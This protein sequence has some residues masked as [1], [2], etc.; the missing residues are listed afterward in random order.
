MAERKP[1]VLVGGRLEELPA[2]DT[3]QAQ[4]GSSLP[5]FRNKIINGD[6]RIDQR[7]SGAAV[8]Y[9]GSVSAGAEMYALDRWLANSTGS[10]RFSMQ[11]STEAP[12]G[13]TNSLLIT[14]T[15]AGT[16]ASGDFC[17]FAQS[18]EGHNVADLAFGGASAKPVAIG[19]WVRS[20]LTGTFG[21]SVANAAAIRRYSFSFTIATANTW[22]YKTVSLVGDTG[23]TWATDT[24]IGLKLVIDLGSGTTN[25]GTAGAWGTLAASGTAPTGSTNLVATA[26]A[27]MHITGVQLEVGSVATPFEHRPYGM[28]LALC[29]RYTRVQT[30]Q[31]P[32][33]TA[34]NL[35]TIDM[36][37]TP[38]I[39]GGGAGFVSTGTTA[40]QLIAFQSSAAVQTLVLN[41][42]L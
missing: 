39:T 26:G 16:P 21:G 17:Y 31:V 22:E 32:A 25:K 8:T 2:G 27:T 15:T 42:E 1:V 29:R 5:G 6:M 13:F 37:A 28:E 9:P 10:P 40:D 36:R 23:G 4:V 19:F 20:S 41:A 3:L 30:Y 11:R 38:T 34:Q 14:T 33:T 7:N 12:P 35:G 18:I 24:G